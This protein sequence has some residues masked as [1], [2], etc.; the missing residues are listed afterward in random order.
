[1]RGGK[2]EAGQGSCGLRRRRLR[3]GAQE[4][5]EPP[6]GSPAGEE[7]ADAFADDA[8]ATTARTGGGGDC[9]GG[10]RA[11]LREAESD[12]ETPLRATCP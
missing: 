3:P 11:Q 8:A 12:R 7:V 10:R 5:S 6:C 9:G 2:D 4:G 1:M